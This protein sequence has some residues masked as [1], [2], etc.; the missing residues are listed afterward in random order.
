MKKIKI[1]YF[2]LKTCLLTFKINRTVFGLEK[3]LFGLHA[4]AFEISIKLWGTVIINFIFFLKKIMKFI[5]LF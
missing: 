5:N 1:F 4:S 3:F 2:I